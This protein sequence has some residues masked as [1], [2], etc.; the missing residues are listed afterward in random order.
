MQ[1]NLVNS[2]LISFFIILMGAKTNMKKGGSKSKRMNKKQVAGSKKTKKGGCRKNAMMK[3]G[4]VHLPA[5]YFGKATPMYG[6]S[7]AAGFEKFAYGVPVPVSYGVIHNGSTGPNLGVFP[8]A[9]GVQTGGCGCT[10]ACM[11]PQV[12]GN[13]K[14]SKNSKS[15]KN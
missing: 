14:K 3:G 2:K 4:R 10:G 1:L 5:E 11:L 13:K 15:K 12:G 6:K 9:S 8:N 7:P